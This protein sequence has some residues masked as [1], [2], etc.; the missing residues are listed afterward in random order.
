MAC[1]AWNCGGPE[2]S[3][4][5]KRANYYPHAGKRK[6][7]GKV[8]PSGEAS[9]TARI[10]QQQ[11]SASHDCTKCDKQGVLEIM[12]NRVKT[13]KMQGARVLILTGEFQGQEGVCL[14]K[15]AQGAGLWAISPDNSDKILS[16]GF[17]RDFG[18]L[19][20]LSANPQL[21]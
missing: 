1:G 2:D 13:E 4:C 16:L 9:F 14:G 15:A 18:L 5:H 6:T 10:D 20:D 19:I 7:G 12:A 17:E 3:R 8:L 21:N 11:L